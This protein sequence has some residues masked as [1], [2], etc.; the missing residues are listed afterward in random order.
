MGAPPKPPEGMQPAGMSA[1]AETWFGSLTSRPWGGPSVLIRAS[2]S[3]GIGCS[4]RRQ[5]TGSVSQAGVQQETL[6]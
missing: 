3:V 4:S 6:R 1:P 2:K 5:L